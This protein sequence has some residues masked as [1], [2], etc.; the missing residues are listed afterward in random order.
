MKGNELFEI[1]QFEIQFNRKV[2]EL[3]LGVRNENKRVRPDF[4]SLF[5]KKS[6]QFSSEQ[7]QVK[8]MEKPIDKPKE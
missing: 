6:A 7:H 8:L 3:A 5:I 1:R 2:S 4:S